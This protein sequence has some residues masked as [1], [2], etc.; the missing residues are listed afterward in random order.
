ME[1]RFHRLTSNHSPDACLRAHRCL[2]IRPWAIKMAMSGLSVD[3]TGAGRADLK[4]P[5]PYLRRTCIRPTGVRP[6]GIMSTPV[7]QQLLERKEKCIQENRG[8]RIVWVQSEC[9]KR[10]ARMQRQVQCMYGPS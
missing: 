4:R 7:T 1:H 5:I 2:L 10:P 9:R 3:A 8:I 6:A